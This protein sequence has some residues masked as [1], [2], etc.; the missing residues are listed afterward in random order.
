MKKPVIGITTMRTEGHGTYETNCHQEYADAISRA[1]GIPLLIPTAPYTEASPYMD[2]LDGIVFS[3]GPDIN[4]RFMNEAP[5][6]RLGG[7][8]DVCDEL[9]IALVKL[10]IARKLPMLGICRGCQLINVALG[11]NLYQDLDTLRKGTQLHHPTIARNAKYHLVD[12]EAGSHVAKA[13]QTTS[14]YTNSFH[15]Q[16]IQNLAEGLIA[17]GHAQDGVIEAYEYQDLQEHYLLGI[18][19]HPESMLDSEPAH[20]HLYQDFVKAA[21]QYHTHK[22]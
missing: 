1:G 9:Q 13:L 16:G 21:K 10:A 18:Q 8:D 22:E 2:V 11:G 17:V 7:I 20:L 3:G 19:W 6:L 14:L 5:Y 15:H 4:P 12:V